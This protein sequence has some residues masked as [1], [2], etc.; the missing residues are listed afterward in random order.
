MFYSH[1]KSTGTRYTLT[2]AL[3]VL[4]LFVSPVLLA[5]SRPVGY[6]FFALAAISSALCL[7]LAW[8]NWKRYSQLSI[9]TILAPPARPE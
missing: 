2:I 4:G 7:G 6:G 3:L 9:P 8:V 1:E 5:V